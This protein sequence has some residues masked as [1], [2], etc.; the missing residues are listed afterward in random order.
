[1]V[2]KA[3][4]LETLARVYQTLRSVRASHMLPVRVHLALCIQYEALCH[5]FTT[6]TCFLSYSTAHFT[7]IMF[8]ERRNGARPRRPS[9]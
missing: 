1:M 6:I 9:T 3:A 8:R 2:A 7:F 5:I 4:F